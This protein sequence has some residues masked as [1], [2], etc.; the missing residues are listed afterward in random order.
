ME[1]GLIHVYTGDGKG[2]TTAATG[3]AYRAK[4]AGLKVCFL[5]L[6]KSGVCNESKF[7]N[8]CEF[9]REELCKFS[10]DMT[11]EEITDYG[12]S[13]LKCIKNIISKDFD[14]IIIDEFFM[15]TNLNI[16]TLDEAC[17]II[18]SKNIKTELILTGRNAPNEIIE[19]ADY[20]S[21]IKCIKHPFNKGITCREGIE[22]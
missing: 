6:F 20:V 11:E 21:E 2:K 4:G 8:Q 3:L 17:D 18:M 14:V 22:F 9:L 15:L 1:K 16:L 12:K 10:W 5:Q 7:F 19:I 13:A